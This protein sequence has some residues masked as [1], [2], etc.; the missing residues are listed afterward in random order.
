[1]RPRLRLPRGLNEKGPGASRAP[2][3]REAV[4]GVEGDG[5]GPA[6][7]DVAG[8]YERADADQADRVGGDGRR[9]GA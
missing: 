3:F 4:L 2:I 1:M 6:G 5:L 7:G 9:R 8:A